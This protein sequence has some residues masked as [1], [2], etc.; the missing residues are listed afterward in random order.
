MAGAFRLS[1]TTRIVV[2][3]AS[4]ELMAVG[5]Y[6]AE[7]LG[8]ATGFPLP[9]SAAG[10]APAAGDIRLTTQGGDPALGDEGYELRIAPDA[11]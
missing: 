11:A 4:A 8:P 3:P 10:G 6:L 7:R 5:Q 9:V 2:Q 1:A